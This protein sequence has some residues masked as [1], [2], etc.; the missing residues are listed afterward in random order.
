[1]DMARIKLTQLSQHGDLLDRYGA[2]VRI[3]GQRE[4][5]KSDV[6]EAMDKAVE[7]T[8][9]NNKAVLN[10]CFPYTSRDEITTAI[11]STVEAWTL[12]VEQPSQEIGRRSPFKE[13]RIAHTIRSQHL[14][15]YT[16]STQLKAA[17]APAKPP[18][19]QPPYQG[20]QS[21]TS[22]TTSLSSSFSAADTQD[23]ATTNTSLA[24]PTLPPKSSSTQPL[25]PSPEL[26]HP[27]T[28]S[29]HM[30]TATN[31]PLDLLI[32]TSGFERLSD[33]MLWQCH[34]TTQIVF[35][36]V[37]WPEF[38]L[39]SFLP[40]LWEWQWRMQKESKM[41]KLR[42]GDE[43][44]DVK[45]PRGRSRGISSDAARSGGGMLDT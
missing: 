2:S 30:F 8:A 38:D 7:M 16:D 24:S 31:P 11:R 1:M 36:S 22:S 23:T 9:H 37:L 45:R 20:L 41:R 19:L 14:S 26:I 43:E 21:P 34:Q 12:P 40:V 39:W 17:T 42:D 6:L 27:S 4:L 18:N 33:F 13:D 3:L 25:Y 10:V 15:D 35:L 5:M 44:E 29:S 32:R 28:L